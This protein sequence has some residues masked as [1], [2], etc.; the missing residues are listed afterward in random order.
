MKAN[1]SVYVAVVFAALIGYFSY[2]WWFN[3]SRMVK[4]P[5]GELAAALDGWTHVRQLRRDAAGGT[6]KYFG[7]ILA[8]GRDVVGVDQSS[9]MLA[10]A[11][12]LYPSARTEPV[13]LQ[14]LT[15]TGE[16]DAAICVDAMENVFPEDW[17]LVVDNLKN[18]LKPSGDLYFTVETKDEGL[19]ADAYADRNADVH[20]NEHSDQHIDEHPPHRQ[21]A[22]EYQNI[23]A[24][25][26]FQAA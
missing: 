23:G 26:L 19:I 20:A 14:E 15:F 5:L 17:P 22:V 10:V 12:E 24:F 1:G 18:A 8:A 7:M 11:Q 13:G 21:I 6:G 2:Q 3:P 4:H 25:A 9:G 16:F